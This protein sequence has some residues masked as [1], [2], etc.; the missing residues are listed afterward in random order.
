M[1]RGLGAAFLALSL[2]AC[3]P[4]VE[5]PKPDF[6]LDCARGFEAL[7][8]DLSAL[9]GYNLARKEQGEPFHYLNAEDGQISYMVTEPG[10]PGHP[11]ILK[12]RVDRSVSPPRILTTGCAYGDQA[13]YAQLVAYLDSLAKARGK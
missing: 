4:Q 10:E 7:S 11:A 1:R 8:A 5:A 6:R 2:S 12:Q 13:G 3:A 9:P